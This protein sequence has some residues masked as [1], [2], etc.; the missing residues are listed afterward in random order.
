ME[1]KH[2]VWMVRGSAVERNPGALPSL[3]GDVEFDVGLVAECSE[4]V[5]RLV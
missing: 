3:R 2:G 1:V 4:R 5:R